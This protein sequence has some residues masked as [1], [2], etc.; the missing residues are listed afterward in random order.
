MP[1][2]ILSNNKRKVTILKSTMT[3][4]LVP[5]KQNLSFRK[6]AKCGKAG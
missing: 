5:K 1:L 2:E 4:I 6:L 3:F